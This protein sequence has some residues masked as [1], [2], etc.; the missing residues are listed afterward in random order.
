MNIYIFGSKQYT[1]EILDELKK[2]EIEIYLN[3]DVNII[4]K[5][6]E[7]LET[8]KHKTD[9]DIFLIDDTIIK[10]DN[11]K[12]S[13]FS[14]FS[15]NKFL[16]DEKDIEDIINASFIEATNISDAVS[17]IMD[18]IDLKNIE[19][20]STISS[21]KEEVE[22]DNIELSTK[23]FEE[24]KINTEVL[25]NMEEENKQIDEK[26]FKELDTLDQDTLLDIFKDFSSDIKSPDIKDVL[27]KMDITDIDDSLILNIKNSL[28]QLLKSDKKVKITIELN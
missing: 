23:V 12:K 27:N 13:I 20:L 24:K 4:E 15:K 18:Y 14:Y 7:L 2:K 8:I 9:N 28:S 17:Q 6:D 25:E 19:E 16:I 26:D 3:G 10:K 5:P 22:I 11:K 21:K 1:N